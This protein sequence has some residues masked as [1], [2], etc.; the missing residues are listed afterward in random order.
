MNWS[1]EK[2]KNHETIMDYQ[3]RLYYVIELTQEQKQILI[4]AEKRS[5]Q[6]RNILFGSIKEEMTKHFQLIN[7]RIKKSVMIGGNAVFIHPY[8]NFIINT[9]YTI[10]EYFRLASENGNAIMVYNRPNGTYIPNDEPISE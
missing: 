7:D 9:A 6:L 3:S 1:D 4:E 2:I 5:E 10:E 8:E